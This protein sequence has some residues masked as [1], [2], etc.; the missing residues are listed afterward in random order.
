MVTQSID[1]DATPLACYLV[2]VDY[3]SYPKFLK[4]VVAVS[5]RKK[6]GNDCEV[7]YR[8]NLIKEITYTLKHKGKPNI[9][10]EWSLLEGE[11]MKKNDGFWRL[12]EV[13]KGLTRAT[14]GIDIKFGLLVPNAITKILVYHHLPT[15]L[16]AFKKR[17]ESLV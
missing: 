17:I 13:K 8:L 7:T 14:Y 12:E 10:M 16:T 3:E 5:V 11:L 2:I 15:M 6:K 1:I 9:G 4:D